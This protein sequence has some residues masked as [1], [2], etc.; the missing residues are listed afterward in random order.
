M[1]S[2]RDQLQAH[3]FVVGRL[4]S[5]ALRAEPDDPQT[6]LR[7]FVVGMFCGL[8]AAVLAV[9]GFAILGLIRP[10]GK[11]A[12]REPGA[13]IVERESGARY[14]FAGGQLQPVL[15]RTSAA[16]ILGSDMHIVSVS[17]RSLAG[18]PHGLPVGI[19][20]APDFL[21]DPARMTG[22]RWLV[23]SELRPDETGANR[24]HVTLWVGAAG[25]GGVATG[26]LGDGEA[27]V[28]RDPAGEMY[29]VWNGRRLRVPGQATLA[30]LGFGTAT[31]YPVGV[32]W[33][34]AVPAGPDL[35]A[36]DV[37]GRGEPGPTLDGLSTR[38][39]QLLAVPSATGKQFFLI[40]RAGLVP[41]TATVAAMVL[42][43]PA[44]ED[45]YPNGRVEAVPLSP[46]ALA[47]APRA[48]QEA[49]GVGLPA[50]PPEPVA[51]GS[52]DVP[53]VSVTLGAEQGPAVQLALSA[54][55]AQPAG[56]ERGQDSP[57]GGGL[58]DR[59][60]VDPG[61]GLLARAQPGPGI[62]VGTLYL[63]TDSGVRYPLPGKD[64]ADTLG[65]GGVP[66]V[67]VP[68]T[69][70]AMLPTGPPLDPAAA[71]AVLPV[72]PP[73]QIRPQPIAGASTGASADGGDAQ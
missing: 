68:G 47:A 18:V 28:A 25:S 51:G 11:T 39:G 67:A 7:R 52:T 60:L 58:V 59:V 27:L 15:N 5:A 38:V 54:A 20:A 24:P 64:V 34:N 30:A 32:A 56:V 33:L 46:A 29:L 10:G 71:R 1:Q 37:P 72:T 6:P 31:Q 16:L 9:A 3:T 45:A 44:T 49:V 43:D 14:V 69:L 23:C 13:L 36:P 22:N 63:L 66:P 21:P 41:L 4:A 50:T 40:Q 26:M 61:A 73:D 48:S 62:A 2:R 57:P 53:C 55:G 42:G 8:M 35:A 65:Y 12:W 19:P 70:L 17:R